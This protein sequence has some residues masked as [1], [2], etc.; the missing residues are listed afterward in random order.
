MKIEDITKWNR[1]QYSTGLVLSTVLSLQTFCNLKN[2]V[3][4][5]EAFLFFL[6]L[7]FLKGF[8]FDIMPSQKQN[9]S[10]MGVKRQKTEKKSSEASCNIQNTDTQESSWKRE[11]E[12]WAHSCME[13]N[14]VLN[15]LVSTDPTTSYTPLSASPGMHS[16]HWKENSRQY[17]LIQPFLQHAEKRPSHV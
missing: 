4:P 13:N 5:W 1:G 8:V 16:M 9:M 12:K 6:F 3:N 17:P 2:V 15:Y 10:Q 7:S 11:L 14:N